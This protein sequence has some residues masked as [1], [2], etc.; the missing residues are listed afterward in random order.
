MQGLTGLAST[1]GLG[2]TLANN[3][4]GTSL[5]SLAGAQLGGGLGSMAG[6][7]LSPPQQQQMPDMA[8]Q[9]AQAAQQLPTV[10][11]GGTLPYNTAVN[12]QY[13]PQQQIPYFNPMMA[14]PSY[15]S[16]GFNNRGQMMNFASNMFGNRLAENSRRTGLSGFGQGI[17]FY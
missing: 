4:L 8:A 17:A 3:V 11:T 7:M 1:G 9:M 16:S 15:V 10:S 5:A 6:M 2:T 13:A 12:Y 14:G